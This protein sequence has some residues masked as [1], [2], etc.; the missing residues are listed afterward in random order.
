[1]SS[2]QMRARA[3]SASR[4][5]VDH[6]GHEARADDHRSADAHLASRRIGEEG[7]AFDRLLELI[8]YG[9]AVAEQCAPVDGRLDAMRTAIEQAHAE[10]VFQVRNRFRDRRL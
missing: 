9:D 5:A 8:A 3:E 7:D 1:D 6:G 10:R 4:Q 2:W